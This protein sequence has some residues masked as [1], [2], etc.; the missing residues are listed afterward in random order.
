G[1][2][3]VTQEIPIEA[4]ILAGALSFV[5]FSVVSMG[6]NADPFSAIGLTRPDARQLGL[7]LLAVPVLLAAMLFVVG[8]FPLDLGG[9]FDRADERLT[10]A[11]FPIAPVGLAG[12]LIVAEEILFR[13]WLARQVT[14]VGSGAIYAAVKAPFDPLGGVVVAAVL[15]FVGARG[16]PWASMLT[17][18][19]TWAGLLV[20]SGA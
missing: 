9:F 19:G 6:R 7:G 1:N 16:G 5:M 13:G 3:K 20:L 2:F 4:G 17:R 11:A 8:Q 12:L 15:G 14:P 10:T 18:F